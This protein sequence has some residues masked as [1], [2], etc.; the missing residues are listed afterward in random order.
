MITWS[1]RW[2][3]WIRW[4]QLK[5]TWIQLMIS[6]MRWI[7]FYYWG[8]FNWNWIRNEWDYLSGRWQFIATFDMAAIWIDFSYRFDWRLTRSR[9]EIATF[10]STHWLTFHWPSHQIRF[11]FRWNSTLMALKIDLIYKCSL[12][13]QLIESI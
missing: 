9:R 8:E 10:G 6:S 4:I 7:G 2:I 1:I 3:R 13:H 5:S 12:I 11:K